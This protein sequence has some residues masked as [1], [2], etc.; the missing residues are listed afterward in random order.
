V[1]E[2]DHP[3]SSED[4]TFTV[5]GLYP[6]TRYSFTIQAKTECGK[7]NNSNEVYGDTEIGGND[8]IHVSLMVS[9]CFVNNIFWILASLI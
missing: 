4:V 6:S 5:T 2:Y 3:P 1:K 7:G 9:A 8:L